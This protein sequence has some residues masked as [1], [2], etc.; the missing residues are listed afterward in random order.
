MRRRTGCIDRHVF[1]V[2]SNNRTNKSVCPLGA[3][4]F[5]HAVCARAQVSVCEADIV[6]TFQVGGDHPMLCMAVSLSRGQPP[7]PSNVVILRCG[8]FLCGAV[9]Q[10][11]AGSAE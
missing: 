11:D 9:S 6:H 2:W 4:A 8:P 5:A 1:F 3:H 7:I 10:D